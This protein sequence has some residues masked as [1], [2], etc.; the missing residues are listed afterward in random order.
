MENQI[1]FVCINENIRAVMSNGELTMPLAKLNTNCRFKKF[2]NDFCDTKDK[3]KIL[4]ERK[5]YNEA[6]KEERKAYNEA[7][8]EEIA[9]QQ[10]AYYESHKEEIAKQKKAYY[11]AHKEKIAKQQKAY[12]KKK[13]AEQEQKK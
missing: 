1:L 9:K 3:N 12:Y 4:K 2:Y 7:H 10:K 6:H 8:K 11:E 5:A 13:L